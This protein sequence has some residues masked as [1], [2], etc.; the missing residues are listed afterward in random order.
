MPGWL[1]ASFLCSPYSRSAAVTSSSSKV[2][3]RTTLPHP[4]CNAQSSRYGNEHLSKQG[5]RCAN[6]R[7]SNP[8][9]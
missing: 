6:V 3:A 9:Q 5:T 7:R 2:H 1:L 8:K 4:S